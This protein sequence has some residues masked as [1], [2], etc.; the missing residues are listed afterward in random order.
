MVSLG[1][2]ERRCRI[3]NP[4]WPNVFIRRG[5]AARS[6]ARRILA[7]QGDAG[8]RPCGENVACLAA[9]R[10]GWRRERLLARRGAP[11]RSRRRRPCRRRHASCAAL[12]GK[13]SLAGEVK[14][15]RHLVSKSGGKR[16]ARSSVGAWS[17]ASER[18]RRRA[19]SGGGGSLDLK[20][21]GSRSR[22]RAIPMGGFALH[23]QRRRQGLP[24][25][26]S[27]V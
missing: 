15:D 24:P 18:R 7:R 2:R 17:P 1:R 25:S 20:G 23:R 16:P 9:Y 26:G 11:A 3:A 13:G 12:F 14:G 8:R 5:C 22:G 21:G 10:G 19:R 6:Q 4:A 27:L